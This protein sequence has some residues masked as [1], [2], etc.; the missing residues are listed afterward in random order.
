MRERTQEVRKDMSHQEAS[1]LVAS[2]FRKHRIVDD[3][4]NDDQIV[5]H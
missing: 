4:D 1:F 5:V 2:L 3:D